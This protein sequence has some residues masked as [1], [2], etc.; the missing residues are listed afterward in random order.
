M[1]KLIPSGA[2]PDPVY[3]LTQLAALKGTLERVKQG[4]PASGVPKSPIAPTPKAADIRRGLEGKGAGTQPQGGKVF[5]VEQV[6]QRVDAYNRAHANDKGFKPMT[7]QE[8]IQDAK[9][10]GHTVQGEK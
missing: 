1:L 8:G 6:Q 10:G 9:T 3:G 4:V 7:L 2:T 5:T